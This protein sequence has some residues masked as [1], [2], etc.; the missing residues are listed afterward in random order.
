[1]GKRVMGEVRKAS[2]RRM[3][4]SA[5]FPY[6]LFGFMAILSGCLGGSDGVENPKMDMKMELGFAPEDGQPLSGRVSLYGKALN[7]VEDSVPLLSKDFASGTPVSF[8]PEEMDAALKLSLSR[9]G[10][11]TSSLRDTTV[12]FNVV[13]A[14]GDREAFIGGFR[15]R[16][17]GGTA[18]FAKAEGSD[19]GAFGK[20]VKTYGLKKAVKAFSGRLGFQ[21]ISL[22]IDYI[23]IPGSPYH[24]SIKKDSSFTVAR[25]SEGMY[26]IVGADSDSALLYE[27]TDTLS[28][29]DSA[30]SA[31]A[32]STIFVIPDH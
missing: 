5:S 10:K 27:S 2:G 4:R 9:H 13:A 8:T 11:D 22:G 1:M 3:S 28:T 15:Y 14:S 31:K 23:F 6:A 7:P 20:L 29:A 32:W 17:L 18:G 30:Y 16:R 25:M 12:H 24:A 26:N 21:G 19:P